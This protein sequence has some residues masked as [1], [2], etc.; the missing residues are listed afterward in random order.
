MKAEIGIEDQ[1]GKVWVREGAIIRWE[2]LTNPETKKAYGWHV[3]I[4]FDDFMPPAV[5]PPEA[6]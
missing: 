2:E 3:S 6:K 1:D 4:I 5:K